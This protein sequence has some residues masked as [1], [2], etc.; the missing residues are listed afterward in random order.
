[1]V[2]QLESPP[3]QSVPTVLRDLSDPK[4]S[5]ETCPRRTRI[6]LDWMLLALEA[7]DLDASEV[8]LAS[9]QT[10]QL[11]D[12]IPN[13]VALW[14]LRNTNPLRR[15]SKRQPLGIE[16]AKA[17]VAIACVLAR[18][19]IVT[20]R[21]LLLAQEQ[22]RAQNLSPDHHG[23]LARYLERFK[24]HFRSRMNPNR[25]A[26]TAYASDVKLH[27]LALHLLGQL[28]FCT[29]TAGK[30]RFWSSLFDGEVAA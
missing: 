25:T 16:E 9:V 22:L 12:L 17:L 24:Q 10:L 29:G 27:Q 4:V 23:G 5:G 21:Q 1:M 6:Q 26:V 20:I 13:R 2:N 15:S 7:L 11:Q 18:S 3:Q 28:L 14:Q 30:Q 8:M 19:Q